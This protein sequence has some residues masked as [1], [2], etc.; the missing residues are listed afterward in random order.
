MVK[1][2]FYTVDINDK[3]KHTDQDL[4]KFTD[5]IKTILNDKNAWS[6]YFDVQFCCLGS[7]NEQYDKYFG[8][9]ILHIYL[10]PE[11][12]IVKECQ[13]NGL[14]CYTYIKNEIYFNY[15]NWMNE[16]PKFLSKFKQ[17]L[18]GYRRYLV[19]HEVGHALGLGHLDAKKF[20]GLPAPIMSQQTKGIYNAIPNLNITLYDVFGTKRIF[21]NGFVLKD[22]Y[23]KKLNLI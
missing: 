19:L 4:Q 7:N 12:D 9:D 15:N 21:D 17:S 8:K 14:S 5:I 3:I 2:F 20:D 18:D 11:D 22:K 23:M 6:K 1:I 13:F 10:T 16:S